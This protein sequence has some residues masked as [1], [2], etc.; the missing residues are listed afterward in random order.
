[1]DQFCETQRCITIQFNCPNSNFINLYL[2]DRTQIMWDEIWPKTYH[3]NFQ[4][5]QPI[6]KY[7]VGTVS[8]P[9]VCIYKGTKHKPS[10]NWTDFLNF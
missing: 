3:T 10:G 9:N 4:K 5:N 8:V 7:C 6:N 2:R 1:M